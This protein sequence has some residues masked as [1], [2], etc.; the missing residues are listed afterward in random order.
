MN[1]MTTIQR[2]GARLRAARKAAGFNTSKSF[3]KKY[4]IPASTYSQHESGARIP[5]EETL[6]FYSNILEVNFT[7]LKAGKGQP[8]KN[9][10]ASKKESMI[11]ELTVLKQPNTNISKIN[12]DLLKDALINALHAF[13]LKLPLQKIQIIA[14]LTA[15]MYSGHK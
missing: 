1:I 4:K 12:V 2:L 15:K 3:L 9:I 5:N 13:T 11:E 8:Y 14:N 7:W 6:K 10:N